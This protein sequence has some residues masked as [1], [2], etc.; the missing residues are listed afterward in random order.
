MLNASAARA[1]WWVQS[2]NDA[3]V[4]RASLVD[5]LIAMVPQDKLAAGPRRT[6]RVS[7]SPDEGRLSILVA[8][9]GVVLGERVV[10]AP[11]A[12]CEELAE[13]AIFVLATLI[14]GDVGLEATTAE[15]P[16]NEGA[17]MLAPPV[18][19]ERSAE[20]AAQ[21]EATTG[22]GE[23]EAEHAE[24]REIE[25]EGSELLDAPQIGGDEVQETSGEERAPELAEP[26][27]S[28]VLLAAGVVLRSGAEP[29]FGVGPRLSISWRR[30]LLRIAAH[31]AFF[32]RTLPVDSREFILN[33][34]EFGVRGCAGSPSGNLRVEGCLGID[35]GIHAGRGLGFDTDERSVLTS[36][37]IA[38]GVGL[39][40]AIGRFFVRGSLEG[41]GRVQPVRFTRSAG[42][43][44][45]DVFAQSAFSAGGALEFGVVL[46]GSQRE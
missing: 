7:L 45:S 21:E 31:G 1:E 38:A 29:S 35:I 24:R 13:A 16:E 19:E 10:A 23:P 28:E 41:V 4:S 32:R 46:D 2:P 9:R 5:G 30:G 14:E 36:I 3:C 12:T 42:R 40:Y 17:T 39:R 33:A 44:T 18:L 8:S 11:G 26:T 37:G 34:G 20:G 25:S 22:E 27:P 6:A 15:L 43:E